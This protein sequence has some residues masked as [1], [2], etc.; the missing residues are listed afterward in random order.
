MHDNNIFIYSLQYHH[1]ITQFRWK[2]A[3]E[4]RTNEESELL[5]RFQLTFRWDFT[6]HEKISTNNLFKL[7]SA[8]TKH[9]KMFR[10]MKMKRKESE[11]CFS[12]RN[13]S[14]IRNFSENRINRIFMAQ[15]FFIY[16]RIKKGFCGFFSLLL[17]LRSTKHRDF[18]KKKKQKNKFIVRR[19][20]IGNF[21]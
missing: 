4:N 8:P 21:F 19:E 2:I 13:D 1:P 20:F 7:H 14:W 11:K 16:I 10:K 15:L 3:C 6:Q 17:I 9:R 18:E 12:S 5:Y